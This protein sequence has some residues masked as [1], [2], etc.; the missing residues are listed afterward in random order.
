MTLGEAQGLGVKELWR[1]PA[2]RYKKIKVTTQVL[3]S[4]TEGQVFF[5]LSCNESDAA[6]FCLGL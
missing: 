5:L 4:L 6:M 2:G 1:A 3:I